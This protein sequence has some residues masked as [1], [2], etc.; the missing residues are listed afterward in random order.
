[1]TQALNLYLPSRTSH[2]IPMSYPQLLGENNID[3]SFVTFSVPNRRIV[4][5]IE[6][7]SENKDNLHIQTCAK[8][9]TNKISELALLFSKFD[10]EA[11]ARGPNEVCVRL[12]VPT[13]PPARPLPSPP[14]HSQSS[15]L[16]S[17]L[18][19]RPPPP[20]PCY[21]IHAPG[22]EPVL[23][24][25]LQEDRGKIPDG[26]S[27]TDGLCFDHKSAYPLDIDRPRLTTIYEEEE[28]EGGP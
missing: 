2:T 25:E 4:R 16:Q 1:M 5:K 10:L 14:S 3:D 17:Y 7:D 22:K 24:N 12:F 27:C 21:V 20:I 6:R 9:L 26:D 18:P 28:G 23:Q 15:N 11:S 13:L 8:S 19:R